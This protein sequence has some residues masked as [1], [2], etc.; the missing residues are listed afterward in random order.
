MYLMKS[1]AARNMADIPPW[2]GQRLSA[3]RIVD[4]EGQLLATD[5]ENTR[6]H[7]HP[8]DLRAIADQRPMSS[9][10]ISISHAFT[11]AGRKPIIHY[12]VSRFDKAWTAVVNA[13]RSW[14]PSWEGRAG[15]VVVTAAERQEHRWEEEPFTPGA[16]WSRRVE[17]K[18]KPQV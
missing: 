16:T 7:R 14:L 9:P 15:V 1:H 3:Q 10:Y 17:S 6:C 8:G 12:L 11:A 5:P 18:G 2:K 4:K 13:A